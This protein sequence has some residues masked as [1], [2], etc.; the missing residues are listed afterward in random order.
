[1]K[2]NHLRA[3]VSL[4]VRVLEEEINKVAV[5]PHNLKPP[6]EVGELLSFTLLWESLSI[7]VLIC[8][9]RLMLERAK[10]S[11]PIRIIRF[12]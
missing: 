9:K 7:S 1:M 2:K 10:L 6:P 3:E 8:V 5:E 12:K 11:N 4:R